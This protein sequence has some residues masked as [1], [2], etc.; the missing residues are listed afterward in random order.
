MEAG[1]SRAALSERSFL[2]P[3][4]VVSIFAAAGVR[5]SE[6]ELRRKAREIGAC[7][8]IGK[9]LFFTEGDV[10]AILEASRPCPSSS[11]S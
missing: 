2:T 10:D 5:I 11:I 1:V 4:A 3:E 6:R 7:C 8:Q 9:A